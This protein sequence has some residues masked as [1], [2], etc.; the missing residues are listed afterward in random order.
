MMISKYIWKFLVKKNSFILLWGTVSPQWKYFS[1]C[2]KLSV[3]FF[4]LLL[5]ITI[6]AKNGINQFLFCFCFCFWRLLPG[7]NLGGK[8]RKLS[9]FF[10]NRKEKKK[11]DMTWGPNLFTIFFSEKWLQ[12][13]PRSLSFHLLFSKYSDKWIHFTLSG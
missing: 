4:H 5:G 11:S 2:R 12:L 13:R 8:K 7:I 9:V 10:C 3:S 6:G 1:Y